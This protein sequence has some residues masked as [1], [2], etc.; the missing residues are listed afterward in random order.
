MPTER[1]TAQ[2]QPC[3]LPPLILLDEQADLQ[4]NVPT[5]IPGA[6]SQSTTKVL[7]Y[8]KEAYYPW[9]QKAKRK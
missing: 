2:T 4:R 8:G 5:R 1:L 7:D 3:G 6:A 9:A